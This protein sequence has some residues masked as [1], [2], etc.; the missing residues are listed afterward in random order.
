[1]SKGEGSEPA[2]GHPVGNWLAVVQWTPEDRFHVLMMA[3][4]SKPAE[5]FAIQQAR[6]A[7]GT[8]SIYVREA[9]DRWGECEETVSP[10]SGATVL[11]APFA[12]FCDSTALFLE[13]MAY[14]LSK[15]R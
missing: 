2:K 7:D 8:V 3:R 1:M 15:I 9:N 5:E 13:T 6:A 12:S 10:F 11:G 14:H 4:L